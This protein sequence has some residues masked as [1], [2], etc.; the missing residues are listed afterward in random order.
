MVIIL[1]PS[2]DNALTICNELNSNTDG[3]VTTI[4]FNASGLDPTWGTV[5]LPHQ[6]SLRYNK[7]PLLPFW[8][9]CI[10]NDIYTILLACANNVPPSLWFC[11]TSTNPASRS[12]LPASYIDSRFGIS[13]WDVS[14]NTFYY[15]IFNM[16][17]PD[18]YQ[19][20]SYDNSSTLKNMWS[21]SYNCDSLFPLAAVCGALGIFFDFC[22]CGTIPLCYCLM[23]KWKKTRRI[24]IN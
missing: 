3:V 18:Q 14:T 23:K 1:R 17:A 11:T 2:V 22:C 19:Y 8:Q 12:C 5:N 13:L 9:L 4:P 15:Y 21:T 20:Y 6:F 16:Q 10:G 7:L 24:P